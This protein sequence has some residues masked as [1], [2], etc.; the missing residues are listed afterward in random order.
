MTWNSDM[1]SAHVLMVGVNEADGCALN[2]A[3]SGTGILWKS[4]SWSDLNTA[5]ASL[6]EVAE[7]TAVILMNVERGEIPSSGIL[8]RWSE[9]FPGVPCVLTAPQGS[10]DRVVEF[11]RAGVEELLIK[12][13]AKEY[14]TLLPPVLDRMV[15]RE[16]ERRFL[17][18]LRDTHRDHL[19]RTRTLFRLATEVLAETNAEG[20]LQRVV[21][22]A[23]E[24]T[25]AKLGTSGHRYRDGV[26]Q[27]RASSRAADAPPCPSSARFQT[28]RGGVYLDLL[29]VSPS[30][31]L[32]DRE[33]RNH[34][35]WQGLP[36]GHVLLKG[37]LGA[38]LVGRDGKAGGVIMVSHKEWGE[39]TEEDEALL[40]QLATL[41]SLGLR[42]V[43]ARGDAERRA[44][45]AEKGRRVLEALM[46]HV[47]EG[48]TIAGGS[49]LD[50]LRV[51]RYG[52]R[53]LGCSS[54]E[55]ENVPI[56]RHAER[57]GLFRC[58]GITRPEVGELPLARA[59]LKGEIV[60]D[61]EWV[62]EG[63]DGS[64]LILLC[65]AGPIQ[66]HQGTTTGGIIAWR[67]ISTLKAIQAS[68]SK[69]RDELEARVSERTSELA[70]VNE[71]LVGTVAEL[72]EVETALE[73]QKEL[74]QGIIDNIPVMICLY[75]SQGDAKWVNREA[76][77]VLGWSLSDV[78]GMLKIRASE[79]HPTRCLGALGT[80]GNQ[81]GAWYDT[82]VRVKDG[83]AVNTSWANVRLSDGSQV[84]IGIDITDRKLSEEALKRYSACLEWSNRELEDF[85]FVAS[86]DLQ[87]PL[88]K[89]H[90]FGELLN[91]RYAHHLD[92]EARD[93]L[94]RM[95][96]ASKRMQ[97]LIRGLLEYSRVVTQAK[98]FVSVSLSAVVQEVLSDLVTRLEQTG[99]RVEVGDL[100]TIQADTNQMRRL[101]Q[102]LI[103]NALKFHGERKPLIRI[104]GCYVDSRTHRPV[105]HRGTWYQVSVQDN[106]IGIE[107]KDL[108][109]IFFPF[110]RV[111]GNTVYEGTGIGLAICRKIV[112]RH[113][114]AI[115]VK[116]T[117]GMGTTF[118]VILPAVHQ[119]DI[120]N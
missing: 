39:F 115:T 110:Q 99:G 65:N 106:G 103:A 32:T 27:V 86:H 13:E 117:P 56:E 20:L 9:E 70:K 60:T 4:S 3:L 114:G 118:T 102:N 96:N 108:D 112:E 85:A 94:T 25:G 21:D 113:A 91:A 73:R 83:R 7:S 87:E 48:I 101:F 22:A 53:L 59:V 77:R 75:D 52:S 6:P 46:E 17:G 14:L 44:E 18:S 119:G 35:A 79:L 2:S 67:D 11:I 57:F 15:R 71:D 26:F 76:Q 97:G 30:I 120:D 84:A 105:R 80:P 28:E 43:E 69:S 19:S 93:Y 33:L 41:A 81:G 66:D 61:E 68:L 88:R 54:E 31:R 8:S 37:L 58:D 51:S 109:R 24:L 16:A 40:I 72:R 104:Q 36:E 50:T 64:R 107:E 5:L 45:E 38:R 82:V 12:D 42:H 34:P 62:M 111:H 116:S 90:S 23:R 100:E 29:S 95:Q 47:P 10:A 63:R 92:E 74:L 1:I 78:K 55:L 89:I 98:P 49:G